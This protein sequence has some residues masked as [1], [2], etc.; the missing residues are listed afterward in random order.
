MGA[1]IDFLPIAVG[2]LSALCWGLS[3]YFIT[4][5]TR[6]LGQYKTTAYTLLFSTL[7]IA[8]FI[9]Y[10]G[11]NLEISSGLLFF[12]LLF[13][14][15]SFFG[16]FFAYRAFRYGSLSITAPIVNSYPAVIV[17]GSILILGDKISPIEGSAIS[18]IIIGII[19]LSTKLSAFKSKS[20][21]IA[22]GVGSALLSMVFLGAMTIFAGAYTAVIGFVL[23]SVIWRG[24]T[25]ILGFVSGFIAKQQMAFPERKYFLPIFA[26]GATDAFGIL[27]FLYGVQVESSTLPIIS[28]L[29]GLAGAVTVVAALIFF[30]ERPEKNQWVGIVLAM[31]GVVVLS[32]FT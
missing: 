12:A 17:I 27:I 5:P 29:A 30:K 8:P 7:I 25:S 16:F 4:K 28:A 22:S 31:I 9:F 6:T 13:G 3:D 23:L 15:V 19:L 32:Y 2:L 26:A 1:Y 24:M 11:I 18:V 10:S 20:K 21:I 14:V